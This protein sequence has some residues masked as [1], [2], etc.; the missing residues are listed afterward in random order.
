MDAQVHGPLEQGEFLYRLGI[1][2][3]A[4]V[5]KAGTPHDQAVAIQ[6]A[7]VRLTNS[8]A[9]GMGRMIKVL[10]LG[11]PNLGPLPGFET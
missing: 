7:L 1:E 10:G 5:L 2:Q 6:S 8:D 3:R 11:S 9:T 4:A